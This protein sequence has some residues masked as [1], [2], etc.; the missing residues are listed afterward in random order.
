MAFGGIN[1]L[2]PA[3]TSRYGSKPLQDKFTYKKTK[4]QDTVDIKKASKK[5][6][7]KFAAITAAIA[8]GAAVIY[9]AAKGKIHAINP[10]KAMGKFFSS[11]K[12]H[13]PH[14]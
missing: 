14:K 12:N 7:T 2:E 5:K 13:I 9:G 11:I 10:F 3:Y 1:F 8:A 4:G 6:I